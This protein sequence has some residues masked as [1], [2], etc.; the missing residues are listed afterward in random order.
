MNNAGIYRQVGIEDTTGELWDNIFDINAKGVF[1]GYQS[2]HPRNAESRRRFH[3]QHIQRG[4]LI[5]SWRAPAYGATKGAVRLFT[6][7]HCHPV[8][9]RGH[10]VQLGAS[11]HH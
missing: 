9:R 3:H 1:L 10:P 6:K 5:G 8:R 7:F 2:G 4:R 11:G